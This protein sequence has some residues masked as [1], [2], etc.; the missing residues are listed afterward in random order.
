MTDASEDLFDPI[1]WDN[2]CYQILKI[3][4]E[5]IKNSP[6]NELDRVEGY[7]YLARLVNYSLSKFL[8]PPSPIRP[9]IDYNSPRIGGD[10]PDFVYGQTL[11][12]GLYDYRIHG[13]K[14]DAFNISFG[15]YYGGLGSDKGLQC[16][17]NIQ[18]KELSIG[19]D[20][21]FELIVSKNNNQGDWLPIIHETNSILIRQTL[22][23]REVDIPADI[24]IELIKTS[25]V[26][27]IKQP[28]TS[29][30][31][32]NTLNLSGMF[33]EGVVK[34]FLHWTHNF[35]SKP[36]EI[37]PTDPDLLKFANGDPDTFYHNGYFELNSD[38]VLLVELAP[39]NCEYWNIQV[40]NYWLE[41]L[42][43]MDFCTHFNHSNARA[44]VDGKYRF[45]ISPKDPGLYNWI[46][47]VE[48]SRGC[49]SI[50]WNIADNNPDV[51]T[52]LLSFENAVS[53]IT[54]LRR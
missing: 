8:D 15:S 12:S 2:Y 25:T 27:H 33:V 6:E 48:H 34:Q 9:I 28:L 43:Y 35:K 52:E 42:D 38:E 23:N 14:N 24:S 30:Q 46:N 49:I 39:P 20:G 21:E 54:K 10:N 32:L 26:D 51:K 41:S 40:T 16:S 4:N 11:I 44:D 36:N 22:L 45:I 47:T 7:R 19:A 5:I 53:K 13:N 17:G 50:R 31:F 29:S 3:G 37:N 1:I 18:L